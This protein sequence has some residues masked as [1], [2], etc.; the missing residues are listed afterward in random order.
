MMTRMLFWYGNREEDIQPGLV[1]SRK[2]E[3]PSLF[4]LHVLGR[5]HRI[6]NPVGRATAAMQE[7]VESSPALCITIE[8]LVQLQ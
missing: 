8:A 4:L 2:V 5:Y 3:L 1:E 6:N 7:V